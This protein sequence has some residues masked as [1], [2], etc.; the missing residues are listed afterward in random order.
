MDI[1]ACTVTETGMSLTVEIALSD[2]TQD[3]YTERSAA[4]LPKAD[5]VAWANRTL[6]ER[7]DV[8]AEWWAPEAEWDR[9]VLEAALGLP[10]EEHEDTE[11]FLF[12]GETPEGFTSINED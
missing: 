4:W 5:L 2:G 12:V 8:T 10:E 6:E 11:D 3:T 7:W 1:T 9:I